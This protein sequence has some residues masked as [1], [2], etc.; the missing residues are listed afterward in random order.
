MIDNKNGFTLIEVIIV[1][2]LLGIAITMTSLGIKI[3]FNSNVNSYG[4]Q[5]YTDLRDMREKTITS[6]DSKCELEWDSNGYTITYN[7]NNPS[8]STTKRVDLPSNIIVSKDGS[9]VNSVTIEFDKASGKLIDGAGT[10]KFSSSSSDNEILITV[11]KETGSVFI[12]E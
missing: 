4:Q 11:V 9:N 6:I 2:A 8:K 5:F 3:L 10:Y 1:I 7:Y 12:D